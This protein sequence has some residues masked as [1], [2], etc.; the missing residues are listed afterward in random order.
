MFLKSFQ[1]GQVCE[2]DGFVT[3]CNQSLTPGYC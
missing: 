1:K 2:T 3:M